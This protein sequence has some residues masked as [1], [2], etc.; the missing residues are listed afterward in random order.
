MIINPPFTAEQV[1][2]LNKQQRS[3]LFPARLAMSK[4]RRDERSMAGV[5]ELQQ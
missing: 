2:F 4:L 5:K 1:E 3:G